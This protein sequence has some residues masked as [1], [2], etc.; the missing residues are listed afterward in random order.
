MVKDT[1]GVYLKD[2][3]PWPDPEYHTKDFYCNDGLMLM[4][5]DKFRKRRLSEKLMYFSRHRSMIK[6]NDQHVVYCYSDK[7]I[8]GFAEQTGYE[9]LA[10]LDRMALHNADENSEKVHYIFKRI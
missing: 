2:L 1:T 8:R 6:M 3:V 7:Q 5:L 9:V 10:S 4:D